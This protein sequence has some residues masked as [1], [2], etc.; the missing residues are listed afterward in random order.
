M[1][2]LLNTINY[3]HFKRFVHGNLTPNNVFYNGENIMI[4]GWENVGNLLLHSNFKQSWMPKIAQSP[5][6]KAKKYGAQTDVWNIGLI[7]SLFA[8]KED[9]DK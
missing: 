2:Q 5:E 8:N 4:L 6:M 7:M 3:V 1:R 9:L